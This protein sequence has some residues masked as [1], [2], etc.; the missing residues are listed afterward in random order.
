MQLHETQYATI[1]CC[2]MPFLDA[3]LMLCFFNCVA[4]ELEELKMRHK[5]V[6]LGGGKQ[7]EARGGII[8]KVFIHDSTFDQQAAQNVSDASHIS[9]KGKRHLV[10]I[11][12]SDSVGG[13]KEC[14]QILTSLHKSIQKLETSQDKFVLHKF[15]HAAA[16][17]A[18]IKT[19]PELVDCV[20]VIG[21]IEGTKKTT[22]FNSALE[23]L[24]R[25]KTIAG[26][27]KTMKHIMYS[28]SSS[29]VKSTH[30]HIRTHIRTHARAHTNTHI[31][32]R[33]HT[34][35]YTHAGN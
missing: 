14:A 18:Y 1:L 21:D 10:W 9:L 35:T 16:A 19:Y 24:K 22:G 28:E 20:C 23:F 27:S 17:D 7:A 8:R 4:A 29:E 11:D 2:S 15:A 3:H 33:T 34:Q 6:L 25:L 30:M 26:V 5:I 32:A 12:L 13:T 31:H